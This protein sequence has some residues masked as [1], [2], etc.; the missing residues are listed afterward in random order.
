[1]H[2]MGLNT[3]VF[4]MCWGGGAGINSV[5]TEDHWYSY[6]ICCTDILT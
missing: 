6:L 1:M 2:I 5:G 3:T 4:G